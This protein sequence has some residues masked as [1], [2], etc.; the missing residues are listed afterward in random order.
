[1]RTRARTRSTHCKKRQTRSQKG[2]ADKR[3]SE[4]ISLADAALSPDLQEFTRSSSVYAEP[5]DVPKNVVQGTRS[6]KS[7]EIERNTNKQV[8]AYIL[9][10]FLLG[11]ITYVISKQPNIKQ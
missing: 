4:F 1:M 6:V 11:G 2:G 8:V 5:G 7:V 10:G 3:S 9:G